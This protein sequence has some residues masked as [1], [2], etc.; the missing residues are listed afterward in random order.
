MRLIGGNGS[1]L[2]DEKL[3]E[4][5]ILFPNP[6]DGMTHIKCKNFKYLKVFFVD[7][8]QVFQSDKEQ[9]DLS[10]FGS[11]NRSNLFF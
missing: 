7:E 10:F 8:R 3:I 11:W 2:L 9:V 5:A 1:L 4:K 6:S